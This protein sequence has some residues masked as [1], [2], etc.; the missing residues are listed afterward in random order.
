MTCGKRLS[1]LRGRLDQLLDLLVGR[2]GTGGRDSPALDQDDRTGREL[3]RESSQAYRGRRRA[4]SPSPSRRRERTRFLAARTGLAAK[5]TAVRRSSAGA[6]KRRTA[7][8]WTWSSPNSDEDV[9]TADHA[10]SPVV[11]RRDYAEVGH[12]SEDIACDGA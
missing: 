11:R 9:L 7:E 8:R 12:E 1:S 3:V 10:G 5:L 2:R 6:V 4:G